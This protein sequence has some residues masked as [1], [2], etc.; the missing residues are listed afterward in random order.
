M[1]G[2]EEDLLMS[3]NY[4]PVT[5]DFRGK[6]WRPAKDFSFA[7]NYILIPISLIE[8]RELVL[9]FPIFFVKDSSEQMFPVVPL[10]F[11]PQGNL[12]VSSEGRWRGKV[13]PQFLVGFPFGLAYNS[14]G[15]PILV[16]EESFVLNRPEE[17]AFP[18]FK[19]DGKLTEE[20]SKIVQF[21][22]QRE[23]GYRLARRVSALLNELEL[24][25]PWEITLKLND[26]ETKIVGLYAIDLQKYLA[27]SDENY[28]KLRKGGALLLIYAHFFSLPNVN[29]LLKLLQGQTRATS[30]KVFPE[31]TSKT[32]KEISE[33]DLENL[34]KNLKFPK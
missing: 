29:L 25:T 16:I 33:K 17:G 3:F 31:A 32:S 34:L 14:S 1:R 20:V 23:E 19:E 27:L 4:V 5:E 8:L 9:A 21:L 13:L 2:S 12:F 26:E 22:I 24:F 10:N 7:R 6:F 18:F 15:E 30:S 11:L 28:L